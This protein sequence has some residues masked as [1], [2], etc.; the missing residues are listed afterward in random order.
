MP[1][2]G[3][4]P[5][6]V[7][8][9]L[10]PVC[11]LACTHCYYDALP[12]GATPTELLT[13]SE[14]VQ[15]LKSICDSFDAD[16]HVEGGEVFLREDLETIFGG[17]PISYWRNVTLTTSG[18]V[19]IRIADEYLRA[20]GDLR[21]SVEGHTDELQRLV[22]GV[23]LKAVLSTC[24]D[25]HRRGVPFTI[26]ITLIRQNFQQLYEMLD[27]LAESGAERFSFFEFQAVGR[28]SN[29]EPDLGLQ[30]RDIDEILNTLVAKPLPSSVKLFKLSLS[31]LRVSL[32]EEKR[33]ALEDAGY[34]I[35]NLGSMANLTINSNG[36]LGIS[37]W[38]ITA[39]T[40]QDQFANI[41]DVDLVPELQK[42]MESDQLNAFCDHTSQIMIRWPSLA[43]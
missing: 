24:T 21:I 40:V 31:S 29:V 17:L 18:T 43:L 35:M 37:P 16:V 33:A 14:I 32:V 28:G 34:N 8:M 15:A 5:L 42:R 1:K 11:N 9:Y 41:R 10:T 6:N 20:L 7:H 3:K 13:P 19:K 12:V 23:S 25:L 27:K 39:H 38:K 4:R 36:D 26:R 22:R 2:D 30:A